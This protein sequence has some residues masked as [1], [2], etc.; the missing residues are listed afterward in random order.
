MHD[1]CVDFRFFFVGGEG[2]LLRGGFGVEGAK[3]VVY[4]KHRQSGVLVTLSASLVHLRR[5]H[6][7]RMISLV[8]MSESCA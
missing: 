5:N 6:G 4:Y 1:G 3:A 8:A 7:P 2:L